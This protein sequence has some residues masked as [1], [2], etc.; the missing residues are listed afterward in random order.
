M[1]FAQVCVPCSSKSHKHSRALSVQLKCAMCCLFSYTLVMLKSCSIICVSLQDPS[2]PRLSYHSW[3]KR[4]QSQTAGNK[5]DWFL[6]SAE[7]PAADN[8]S[9][10]WLMRALL[11]GWC[12]NCIP[13]LTDTIQW[14]YELKKSSITNIGKIQIWILYDSGKLL[15]RLMVQVNFQ[16]VD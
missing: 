6:Q 10:W 13:T 2:A 12:K 5:E 8:S 4:I 16:L 9:C 14:S 7:G 1:C 3:L 15:C 11:S